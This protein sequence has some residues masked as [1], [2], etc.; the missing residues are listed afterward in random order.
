MAAE[1]SPGGDGGMERAASSYN[2]LVCG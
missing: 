2:S 1:L